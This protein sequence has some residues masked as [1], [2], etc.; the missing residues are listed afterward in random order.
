MAG[1]L[2]DAMTRLSSHHPGLTWEGSPVSYTPDTYDY[3]LTMPNGDEAMLSA[4]R[5][6]AD[7]RLHFKGVE[8]GAALSEAEALV[9]ALAEGAYTVETRGRWWRRSVVRIRG[10][11]LTWEGS[12]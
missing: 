11:D 3:F 10:G 8:V 12:G 9:A 7:V 4:T 6:A 1:V 5:G 2:D